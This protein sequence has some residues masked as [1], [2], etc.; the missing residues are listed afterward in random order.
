MNILTDFKQEDCPN[1]YI[2]FFVPAAFQ[3]ARIKDKK[4]FY[5][6][7]GHAPNYLGKTDEQVLR[8]RIAIKENTISCLE[9]ELKAAKRKPRAPRKKKP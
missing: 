1:C 4:K 7:N 3:A 9:S 8:E 6:P 2:T 5:C